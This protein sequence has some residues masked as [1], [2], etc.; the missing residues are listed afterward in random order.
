MKKKQEYINYL[1]SQRDFLKNK[2][3]AKAVFLGHGLGPVKSLVVSNETL[4]SFSGFPEESSP[5]YQD[6]L[7]VLFYLDKGDTLYIFFNTLS[8]KYSS[9]DKNIEGFFSCSLGINLYNLEYILL[10]PDVFKDCLERLKTKD[11]LLYNK[12]YALA[13]TPRL[14]YRVFYAR[15]LLENLYPYLNNKEK[16]LI[17]SEALRQFNYKTE[18]NNK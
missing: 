2:A 17:E 12:L 15:E 9:L 4:E 1:I 14:R 5:E 3:I 11:I 18:N 16:E 6:Y 7:G 10:D 8:F 13:R